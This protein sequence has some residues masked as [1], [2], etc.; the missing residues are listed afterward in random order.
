[1][2]VVYGRKVHA[3][4]TGHAVH[5]DHVD[6]TPMTARESFIHTGL[7]TLGAVAYLAYAMGIS[8]VCATASSSRCWP[9]RCSNW[10]LHRHQGRL[11]RHAL[12]P[13]EQFNKLVRHQSLLADR[14]QAS[15]D[16]IL[17]SHNNARMPSWCRSTSACWTCMS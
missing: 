14:Q 3:A 9:K 5:H 16:L 8:W 12:Q 17:R 7:F 6:G 10:R 11:L 1:M 13:D 4:A 15:R 2:M